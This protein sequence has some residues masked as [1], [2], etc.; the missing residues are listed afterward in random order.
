[1]FVVEALLGPPFGED[2]AYLWP[3]GWML[4]STRLYSVL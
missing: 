3:T 2:A 4:H 1:L